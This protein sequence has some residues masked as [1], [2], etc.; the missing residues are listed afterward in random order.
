MNNE[1]DDATQ[2]G[3]IGHH[4]NKPQQTG[5]PQARPAFQAPSL[6]AHPQEQSGDDEGTVLSVHNANHYATNTFDADDE[7]TVLSAYNATPYRPAMP[8]VPT[9]QPMKAQ[10]AQPVQMQQ[11]LPQSQPI[12]AAAPRQFPKATAPVAQPAQPSIPAVKAAASQAKP[13]QPTVTSSMISAP[14]ADITEFH[15]QFTKLVDSVSQV[16]VGKEQPIRQC[17]TAMIV[18]GHILLEDNP[19]TGKTQLARGLANSISTGFKRVQFTPDLLP[20]DVVGVTFYDQKRGEFEFREGPIFASIV[21][22]DEIN[23]ASPKTQS[24]LLEVMEEQ[25][26]TVDGVT[27]DVPQPFIVIATQNPIEQLGTYKLPEAQMDRFLIKTSIGYPGHDVSV[28]ILKQVDITDRA[29]TISP[30]LS[31]DDVMRLRQVATE[32]YVD[33][34]IR[35]YI[36]RLVEATRHNEKITVGSSMRGALAL[37]RCARIWAAA[38]GRA[39]VVPDD[40]KDLAVAVLAHRITL[41]PEATFDGATPESLIA[42]VLEDVPSPTIG[43]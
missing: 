15:N 34:A 35:E 20:S 9:T 3:S 33:D 5:N 16:V 8:T 32:I 21:L 18:G 19:G 43:S 23:R 2:L 12:P 28:D 13:A 4:M 22:A 26:V 6:P 39:Y 38:D 24:A 25:K 31:G 29:Q 40:V 14:R 7:G 17:A 1:N 30:V 11:P 41:T 37:T 27:H 42:Q 10:P 36:V